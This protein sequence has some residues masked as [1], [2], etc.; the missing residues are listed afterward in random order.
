MIASGT[1]TFLGE[2]FRRIARRRGK[3]AIVAISC[4][5][6]VIVWHL[7][8]GP[9]ARFH[10]LGPEFYGNRIGPARKKRTTSASSRPSATRSRSNPRPDHG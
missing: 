4:S 7:L 2:R 3:K 9:D 1:D 10:D 5:I 6:L 8:S